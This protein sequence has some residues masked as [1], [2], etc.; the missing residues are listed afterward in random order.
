MIPEITAIARSQVATVITVTATKTKASDFGILFNIFNVGQ[1]NVPITTIN[2]NPTNAAIGIREI[3]ET[4]NTINRIKKIDAEIHEA[5]PLH[6][7]E[8]F[9]I[10][11]PIIA[12][13]HID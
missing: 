2:I 13:P 5:L 8:I 9:I 4:P 6:P 11:C 3:I 7:L 1:A 12:H 10:D